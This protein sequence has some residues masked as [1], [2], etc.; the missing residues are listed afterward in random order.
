MSIGTSEDNATSAPERPNIIWIVLDEL[1]PDALGC[2]GAATAD[3]P[4]LD[5]LAADGIRFDRAYCQSPVC[6]P[7][8]A[9]FMTG[10]YPRSVDTYNNSMS[11]NLG[12][13]H[14]R[15]LRQ[16]VEDMGLD[17]WAGVLAARRARYSQQISHLPGPVG[18][19]FE[20]VM[21]NILAVRR[22]AIELG[23]D[24]DG[25][26]HAMVP[27]LLADVGYTTINFGKLH[28]QAPTDGFQFNPV[29]PAADSVCGWG[30]RTDVAGDLDRVVRLE[31]GRRGVGLAVGGR[32]P[33]GLPSP[34]ANVTDAAIDF[35]TQQH[36]APFLARVSYVWPHTPVLPVAPFDRLYG[37]EDFPINEPTSE[38]LATQPEF[39][40]SRL[41]AS[42]P[43][44]A[45]R[46]R[47]DYYGLV[48]YMD[49][50]IGRLL[51]ALDRS[52]H[53]GNTVVV[54]HA[55]HGQLMGEHGWWS[56]SCFYDPVV[57]SPLLIR[58]PANAHAGTV[59]AEP[60]ELL[61]VAPTLLSLAGAAP[62][63]EMEGVDLVPA[64]SGRDR[65]PH[66]YAFS[67]IADAS[68]AHAVPDEPTHVRRFI[69]DG[70]WHLNATMGPGFEVTDV[71]MYDL[72]A[73]SGEFHNLAGETRTRAVEL[74]LLDTLRDWSHRPQAKPN[75]PAVQSPR[76]DDEPVLRRW[77]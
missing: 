37:E 76:G 73:D 11:L 34:E 21:A 63:A 50:E 13:W 32:W 20:Q 64:M 30:W 65:R 67:E 19:F 25:P 69:S 35:V 8:R 74:D 72:E 36:S 39:I 62:S 71:G 66:A 10:K 55:D 48:S 6:V 40:R 58:L 4:N 33:E 28:H 3:T 42:P 26:R 27:E 24:E 77:M 44:R 43:A 68:L 1:R 49:A 41:P 51:D 17:K 22:F 5:R 29:M 75:P 61:D 9:S 45:P 15:R 31:A 16:A 52:P 38:E 56:K 12:A 7:S 2:Y 23:L 57:R 54:L 14:R 47:A 59:I 60:V 46:A 18:D 53:G 70:Q